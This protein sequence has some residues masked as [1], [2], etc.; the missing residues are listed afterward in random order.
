MMG[1]LIN[2]FK[3]YFILMI[4]VK[5]IILLITIRVMIDMTIR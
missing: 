4:D 5:H 2:H 1:L 3:V